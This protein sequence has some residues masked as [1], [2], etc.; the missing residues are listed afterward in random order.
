VRAAITLVEINLSAG[1]ADDDR[2]S[3]GR[4]LLVAAAAAQKLVEGAG[5]RG[6]RARD[7]Y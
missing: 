4:E 6:A 3:R 7:A 1:G 2:L 5:A